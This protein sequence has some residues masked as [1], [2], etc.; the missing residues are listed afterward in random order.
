MAFR[1]LLVVSVVALHLGVL[2]QASLVH[3]ADG[4]GD[5]VEDAVDRCPV[6]AD[7]FQWDL[8]GDGLGDLCDPDVSTVATAGADLL[9]GIENADSLDGLGGADAI[10]PVGGDDTLSGPFGDDIIV[11]AGSGT[12]E[13]VDTLRIKGVASIFDLDAQSTFLDDGSDAVATVDVSG[14]IRLVGF[15]GIGSFV[16]L[17]ASLFVEVVTD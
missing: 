16:N 17:D 13:G 5:A 2:A 12:T 7:P 15:A 14:T 4:D 1:R 3:A 10:Y 11:D 9:I 6:V 8:D